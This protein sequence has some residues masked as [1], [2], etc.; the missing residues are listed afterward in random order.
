MRTTLALSG[1]TPTTPLEPASARPLGQAGAL[2]H[3]WLAG[4]PRSPAV[5]RALADDATPGDRELARAEL[6]RVPIELPLNRELRVQLRELRLAEHIDLAGAQAVVKLAGRLSRAEQQAIGETILCAE[7]GRG[8]EP[9][10][11]QALRA[12]LADELQA[13]TTTQ[14]GAGL[15][16]G[17]FTAL[18]LASGGM[19]AASAAVFTGLSFGSEPL[20]TTI[21]ALTTLFGLGSAVTCAQIAV[22]RGVDAG[23]YGLED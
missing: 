17:A 6:A 1:R 5:A 13:R 8:V 22:S 20:A 2:T 15:A 21:I 7:L 23:T 11:A 12:H 3:A 10:A 18:T 19:S 4:L 14:R 16:S 9:A